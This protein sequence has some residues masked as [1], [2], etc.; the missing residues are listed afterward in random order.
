MAN[1]IIKVTPGEAGAL[2]GLMIGLI[3]IIALYL[4]YRHRPR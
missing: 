4:K 3:G 1:A 2:T